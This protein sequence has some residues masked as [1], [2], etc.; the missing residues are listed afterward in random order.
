M[1]VTQIGTIAYRDKQTNEFKDLKPLYAEPGECLEE[2]IN[3]LALCSIRA[4]F[5]RRT[6]KNKFNRRFENNVVKRT[7]AKERKTSNQ[8]SRVSRHRQNAN[9]PTSKL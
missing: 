4:L 1:R 2:N 6:N 7:T 3:P 8:A 5:E 9:V